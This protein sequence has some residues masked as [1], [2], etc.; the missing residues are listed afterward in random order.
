MEAFA[1]MVPSPRQLVTSIIAA[2]AKN[3]EQPDAPANALSGMAESKNLL[4]TLHVLF[5]NE[6]LP[7]LD[8]LDRGLVTRLRLHYD[9]EQKATEPG[10]VPYDERAIARKATKSINVPSEQAKHRRQIYTYYVRSSQQQSSRGASRYHDAIYEDTKYYKVELNAWSCSCPAFAFSVFS[11]NATQT[12]VLAETGGVGARNALDWQ[13]GGLSRG[14]DLPICKHLLACTLI[15]H[16]TMFAHMV[17][18]RTVSAAEIAGW[19]AG[20]GD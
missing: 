16:S 9:D 3:E 10:S 11:R 17:E 12:D 20:W 2:L 4:L 8:V 18:E 6:L 5:Q 15:E 14:D 7:A 19:A 13:F 1:G